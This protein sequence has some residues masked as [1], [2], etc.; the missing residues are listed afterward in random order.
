MPRKHLNFSGGHPYTKQSLL[1]KDKDVY[2]GDGRGEEKG[3]REG[4]RGLY[5]ENWLQGNSRALIAQ[6]MVNGLWPRVLAWCKNEHTNLAKKQK[7]ILIV[8]FTVGVEMNRARSGYT[9]CLL[10]QENTKLQLSLPSPIVDKSLSWTEY[11]IWFYS[12]LLENNFD[13]V[14]LIIR[15]LDVLLRGN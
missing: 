2:H 3:G 9:D 1:R 15:L 13:V 7:I 10:T 6:T 12:P 8:Y 11:Q 5:T 14:F 4:V